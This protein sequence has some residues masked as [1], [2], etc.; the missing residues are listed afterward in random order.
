MAA[1]LRSHGAKLPGSSRRWVLQNPVA[2]A[3]DFSESSSSTF[4]LSE[5]PLPALS[6]GEALVQPIYFS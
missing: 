5:E 1:L 4:A 2:T 3:L 6:N